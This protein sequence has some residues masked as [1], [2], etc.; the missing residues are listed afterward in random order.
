M[1]FQEMGGGDADFSLMPGLFEP[2]LRPHVRAFG[3]FVS[4]ADSVVDSRALR[5]A[6]KVERLDRLEAAITNG[7]APGWSPESASVVVAFRGSIEATGVSPEHAQRIVR[8]FRGDA[9]GVTYQTWSDLLIYCGGAAAPIGR[10]MLELLKEDPETCGPASDAGCAALHI[11]KRLRDARASA[12]E[13]SRLCIP[14]QFIED[15]K[16]SVQHL[17]AP[18][19]KGQTRSVIDRVLDGVD[20]LLAHTTPLP[21]Q[22]HSRTLKLHTLIV[23]C[24][25]ARLAQRFRTAD[26][27]QGRVSLGRWERRSCAWGSK[28][29]MLTG[30]S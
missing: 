17:Q 16:I 27:L 23:L 26:P 22:L 1:I 28:L 8:A 7:S 6:E 24:R 25:G 19:A 9:E 10:Y 15:A 18:S 2:E 14:K 12:G 11:L 5:R 4:L 3:Q 21:D 30:R 13:Y 29:R 20:G